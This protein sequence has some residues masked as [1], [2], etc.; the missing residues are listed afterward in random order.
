M[1]IY[2]LI[3]K[4]EEDMMLYCIN[5]YANGNKKVSRSDLPYILREWESQ[6]N[7]EAEEDQLPLV[8]LLGGR[9]IAS[10]EIKYEMDCADMC[11]KIEQE[12]SCYYD[13]KSEFNSLVEWYIEN[14]C[15]NATN[16]EN[17][18]YGMRIRDLVSLNTLACGEWRNSDLSLKLGNGHVLKIC[19]GARPLKNIRKFCDS[20]KD[21]CPCPH[22][23]K[24]INEISVVRTSN[25]GTA[26]LCVSVHP[27]D[28]MTMSDNANGWESC[29]SWQKDGCYRQGTV[30]MMNSPYVVVAYLKS[31]NNRL[32]LSRLYENEQLY[33]NSKFWRELFV[34]TNKTVM[35]IK[36]YPNTNHIFAQEVLN[37]ICELAEKNLGVIY[38][39]TL[40][41][42]HISQGYTPRSVHVSFSD[43]SWADLYPSFVCNTMYNDFGREDSDFILNE[44]LKPKDNGD[45]IELDYN[46]SGRTECMICGQLGFEVDSEEELTCDDCSN[47]LRCSV[48]GERLRENDDEWYYLDGEPMCET[49]YNDRAYLSSFT[50]NE[51][52]VENSDQVYIV[53]RDTQSL[54]TYPYIRVFS[55][56]MTSVNWEGVFSIN[57]YHTVP[58]QNKDYWG[59]RV[60]EWVNVIYMDEVLDP[61]LLVDLLYDN[62]STEYDS[63]DN[64]ERI[65]SMFGVTRSY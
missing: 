20:Y 7:S 8:D 38:D 19:R 17:F 21:V 2:D 37:F 32:P 46:Y 54:L 45:R 53:P 41:S 18:Y 1:S 43:D 58:Y 59:N 35:G 63:G 22:L 12:V 60:E 56:D 52:D 29:M 16:Y 34:V 15:D 57:Q 30:E 26:E 13:F 10:K 62:E 14:K 3:N 48:C 44:N 11:D 6:K 31:N 61:Q 33:W 42:G 64:P 24:F 27:L 47:D 50:K 28:Y 25:K 4:N 23:E 36:G 49:C 51:H 39:K 55:E 65:E 40:N 9:L 5:E